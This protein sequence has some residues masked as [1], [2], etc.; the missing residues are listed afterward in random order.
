MSYDKI[1][2]YAKINLALNVVGKKTFLHK[3]ET[4][5]AF[6]SLH[7]EIFV[8]PI[9]SDS[10]KIFFTGEFSK[11]IGKINTISMLIK[12]LENR[13]LLK[14]QKFEI[15]VRKKIP[16]RAGLGGGSM[17]AANII[18]YFIKKNI[19]KTTKKDLKLITKLVG[20]DVILGLNSTNTVYHSN[21]KISRFSKCKKFF[22]L[23][24]KPSYG[25]ST[26]EIYSKVRKFDKPKFNRP[27]K[28]MFN[29]DYLKKMNNSLE[30]IVLSKFKRLRKV[31]S[32]LDSMSKCAFTRMTG[33]GSAIVAYFNS[34]KESERAKQKFNKR[35]KNFWCIASKTI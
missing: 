26:K 33:S 34:K 21:D 1:K 9:K 30:P 23:I 15:R 20:S 22:V 5:V 29:F 11:K 19:I 31:K 35:Y 18:N 12:I 25:C 32:Y 28:D 6:I 10:H 14:N 24:V 3:I 4:I 17:N 8:R 13:N 2:S 27:D 16:V 7:D